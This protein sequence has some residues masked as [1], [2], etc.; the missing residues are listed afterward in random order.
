MY[1]KILQDNVVTDII[2]SE[3]FVRFQE[4]HNMIIP[5]SIEFAN[6]IRSKDGIIYQ[7]DNL[8]FFPEG[9]FEIAY[10]INRSEYII[11]ADKLNKTI[12]PQLEDVE[13]LKNKIIY[14]QAEIDYLSMMLDIDL[15]G[16]I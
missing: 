14:Q 9:E 4:K 5:C 10:H 15:D 3:S 7:V 13:I 11:L 16:D 1:Y 12:E 8:P 6:G 2:E